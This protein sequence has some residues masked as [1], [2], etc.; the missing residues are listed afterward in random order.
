[1][2]PGHPDCDPPNDTLGLHQ[3]TGCEVC[4]VFGDY[5]VYSPHSRYFL[6]L[7]SAGHLSLLPLLFTGPE[8]PSKLLLHTSYSLA[9]ATTLHREDMLLDSGS[10]SC[11]CDHDKNIY[12]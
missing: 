1:M 8:L 9:L 6:T 11:I 5:S 4:D 10:Y 3:Q 7:T 2:L 12:L